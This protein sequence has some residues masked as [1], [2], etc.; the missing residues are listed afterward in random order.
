LL[1]RAAKTRRRE[2]VAAEREVQAFRLRADYGYSFQEIAN[3]LDIS[4][5]G[6]WKAYERELAAVRELVDLSDVREHVDLAVHRLDRVL[7]A[8]MVVVDD[9]AQPAEVRLR[10]IDRVVRVEERR[11]RLLGLDAPQRAELGLRPLEP[12][13]VLTPE[14]VERE[15]AAFGMPAAIAVHRGPEH[16]MPPPDA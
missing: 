8:A 12:P 9:R 4:V 11:A 3:R 14:Q 1:S 2:S 10:A 16:V 7:G 5:S 13:E 15:L 6:A